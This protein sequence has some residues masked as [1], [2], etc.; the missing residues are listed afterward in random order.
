MLGWARHLLGCG[1]IMFSGQTYY[2]LEEIINN[3]NLE[4]ISL[5]FLLN[6]LSSHNMH[7]KSTYCWMASRNCHKHPHYSIRSAREA[8]RVDWIIEFIWIFFYLCLKISKTSR[9]MIFKH[10]FFLSLWVSMSLSDFQN[11]R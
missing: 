6:M 10:S 9:K 1:G 7:Y 8:C 2:P 3:I 5:E 11:P 4:E